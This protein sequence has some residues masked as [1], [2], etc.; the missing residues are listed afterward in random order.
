MDFFFS[1]SSRVRHKKRVE[2]KSEGGKE[3]E[4]N[5]GK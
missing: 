2:I 3:W 4:S 1:I 5:C